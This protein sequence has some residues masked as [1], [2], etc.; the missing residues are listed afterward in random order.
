MQAQIALKGTSPLLMHNTRLA[1][2]DDE[3]ARA[4]K[5]ITDKRK[6]TDDDRR[7]K[8]RLEWFGGLYP[9]DGKGLVIP[10]ANIRKCLIEAGTIFRLGKQVGRAV[11]FAEVDAP[12]V[13]AGSTDLD[14]LYADP[15]HRFR[16]SVKV[17]TSRVPR[18]RPRFPAWAVTTAALLLTDVL[19]LSDLERIT[20]LAGL[21]IG[22]GDGRNIG[23]GRFEGAVEQIGE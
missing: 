15:A 6:M 20:R 22:L 16:V 21:S 19:N 4:I 11:V 12:L 5:E 14:E 13:Y 2:P 18:M 7:A 10:A 8:E 1:D 3:F 23:F 9:S 17:G